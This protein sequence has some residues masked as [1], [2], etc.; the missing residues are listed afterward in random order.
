MN[1]IIRL[2]G[3]LT[4]MVLMAFLV[5]AAPAFAQEEMTADESAEKPE[6]GFKVGR[7]RI[8]PAIALQ[9]IFDS[10]VQNSSDAYNSNTLKPYYDDILRIVGGLKFDYPH[11]TIAVTLLGEAGYSRYFG[12]DSSTT[13][14]LSSITGRTRLSATLFPEGFFSFGIHDTYTRESTPRQVALAQVYDRNHNRAMAR[15]AFR[16][17]GGQ[18]RF[19]IEYTNDLEHYADSDLSYLNWMD[20]I[21][22]FRWELEFMPDTAVYM[23]NSFA[24]RSYFDYDRNDAI[25][26]SN[27]ENPEA[28]PLRILVGVMGRVTSKLLINVA[29]GYGNSFH[30][31][32][33][34]YNM[35]IGKAE[36][37][38]RFTPRTQLKFGYERSFAPIVTFAYRVDNKIY[39]E[40]KQWAFK[41]QLKFY[42]HGSFNIVEYGEADQGVILDNNL[43]NPDPAARLPKDRLDFEASFTPTLRYEPLV[44]LF[45]EAAYTFTYVWNNNDYEV[46]RIDSTQAGTDEYIQGI[47]YFDYMKHQVFFTL[48]FAY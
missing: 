11:P 45:L 27:S 23:D 47:G 46:R 18:L 1:K 35:F 30:K 9:N 14:E 28:M 22:G 24:L 29:A 21:F 8:H 34:D 7:A 48:G 32:F 38:G 26:T 20:H 44:W 3:A 16:P 41:D 40:F 17:G 42:L 39:T 37:T 15:L 5:C 12:I 33:K 43:A 10:N 6:K 25:S 31:N 4:W 19:Y 13:K 36:V 2:P